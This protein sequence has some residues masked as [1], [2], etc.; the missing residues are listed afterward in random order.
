[1]QPNLRW[2]PSVASSF[3]SR[4]TLTADDGGTYRPERHDLMPFVN[5][6]VGWTFD[7]SDTRGAVAVGAVRR[8]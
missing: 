1:V 4:R 2:W 8:R 6:N 5:L 3:D 7:A